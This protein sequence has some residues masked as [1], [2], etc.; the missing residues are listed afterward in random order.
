MR[1]GVL[2]ILLRCRIS[3]RTPF[4]RLQKMPLANAEDESCR[5]TENK[6][7]NEKR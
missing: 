2:R 7:E 5:K 4:D 6:G 3:P 1:Y